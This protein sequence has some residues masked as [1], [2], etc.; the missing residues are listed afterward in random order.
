M[1]RISVGLLAAV[2][3]SACGGGGNGNPAVD[4]ARPAAFSDPAQPQVA[5]ISGSYF[6]VK[7]D[8]STSHAFMLLDASGR[9]VL[10]NQTSDGASGP[11]AEDIFLGTAVVSGTN[12]TAQEVMYGHRDANASAFTADTV[13]VA[14]AIGTA[15]DSGTSL[16]LV[17]S[18]ATPAPIESS[19]TLT[20]GRIGYAPPPYTVPVGSY[21]AGM[22][23]GSADGRLV[24]SLGS[25]CDIDAAVSVTDPARNVLRMRAF[26]TGTGCAAL[27]LAAGSGELLGYHFVGV[28]QTLG[29]PAVSFFG[30]IGGKAVRLYFELKRF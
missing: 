23:T 24:G 20:S 30:V 2:F 12:W 9:F 19:V 11:Y 4:A 26:L 29:P 1:V 17:I 25:G 16:A 13:Q 3:L 14:G 22:V 27:G 8:G 15:A 18:G 28:T 6:G 7:P 10:V 21:N 5:A